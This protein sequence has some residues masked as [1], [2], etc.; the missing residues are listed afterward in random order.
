MPGTLIPYIRRSRKDEKNEKDPANT[1]DELQDQKQAIVDWAQQHGVTLTDW[2]QD[3][4]VSGNKPWRERE[5]GGVLQ[6]LKRG[7]A[8]GIIVAYFS[9]LS[10]AEL[11]A[12]LQVLEELAPYRR[13]SAKTGR[14]V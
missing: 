4:G 6:R 1:K 7:E 12:T 9:R 10:R 13:V 14:V 11:S 8:D 5:L 2:V 3:K